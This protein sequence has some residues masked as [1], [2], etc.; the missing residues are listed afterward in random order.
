MHG[1][2][3]AHWLAAKRILRYLKG[4]MCHG[5]LLRADAPLNL[6][7]FSD[8]N[9]GGPDTAGRSTTS[10]LIYLGSNVI[11]WKSALQKTVSRSSTEAE[12]RAIANAAAE[13]LWVQHLLRELSISFTAPP[14]LFTDS[15]SATYVCKNPVFHSRMKH[16]A[17]DYFFVRD[18]VAAGSLLVHHVSSKFQRADVLTKPLGRA[19][20]LYFRSKMGVSDG[21][22]ILRG[23]IK[24]IH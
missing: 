13:V 2:L 15:L 1:P 16:L 18:L 10:Y 22:S 7:A 12:Y 11:S 14:R 4:T 5:L 3:A 6:T 19:G 24:D 8:A 9:W 23:R 21:S 17:L 20:F